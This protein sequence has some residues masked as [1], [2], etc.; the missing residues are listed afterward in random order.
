MQWTSRKEDSSRISAAH[1]KSEAESYDIIQL[2][3]RPHVHMVGKC[4]VLCMFTNLR[5]DV[6]TEFG[7]EEMVVFNIFW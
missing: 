5:C 2:R 1:V 6:F 4:L 3:F 7:C